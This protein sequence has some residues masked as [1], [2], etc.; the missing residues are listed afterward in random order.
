MATVRLRSGSGDPEASRRPLAKDCA[1][2][3]HRGSRCTCP[4]GDHK[5][6]LT[7]ATP[8]WRIEGPEVVLKGMT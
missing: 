4:Q 7:L 2:D 5:G 8:Y 1:L 3:I 6:R